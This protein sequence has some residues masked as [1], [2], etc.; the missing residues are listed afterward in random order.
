MKKWTLIFPSVISHG[1][2]KF[3]PSR[4]W[5]CSGGAT[6]NLGTPWGGGDNPLCQAVFA[7]G[8]YS[9]VTDWSAMAQGAAAG[10]INENYDPSDPRRAHWLRCVFVESDFRILRLYLYQA[11]VGFLLPGCKHSTHLQ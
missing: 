8:L 4:Q 1:G 10:R 6:P 11:K 9:L 2:L 3:P 5:K 7:T